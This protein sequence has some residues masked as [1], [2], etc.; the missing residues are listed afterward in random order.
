VDTRDAR[1]A[2]RGWTRPPCRRFK[3][4]SCFGPGSAFQ[5]LAQG[6]EKPPLERPEAAAR[7]VLEVRAWWL[8]R[9][10]AS[11][12]CGQMSVRKEAANVLPIIV[13]IRVQCSWCPPRAVSSCQR[14]GE[15]VRACGAPGGGERGG[16]LGEHECGEV[17]GGERRLAWRVQ[18]PELRALLHLR[19]RAPLHVKSRTQKYLNFS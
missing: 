3:N 2:P 18:P 14:V 10:R 7:S 17:V 13:G 4:R 6:L 19:N 12:R 5:P 15:R 1:R 8:R 11:F 16:G 9:G